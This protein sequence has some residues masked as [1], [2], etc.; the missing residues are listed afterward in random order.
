[1]APKDREGHRGPAAYLGFRGAGDENRTRTISLGVCPLTAA[2]AA[3]LG[4]RAP[5]SDHDCLPF[6]RVNGTRSFHS[7]FRR[8]R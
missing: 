6:T 2:R 3:E 4:I 5:S 1:M 7:R 8:L